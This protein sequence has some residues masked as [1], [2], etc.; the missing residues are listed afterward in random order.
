V[1]VCVCVCVCVRARACGTWFYILLLNRFSL[2]IRA[3]W[4]IAPYSLRVD[5]RFRSAYCL[6]Q[7][8]QSF[9]ALTMEAVRT[10]ET[11]VY[12]NEITRRYIADGSNL[13]TRRRNNLTS[14]IF[15]VRFVC[16]M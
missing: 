4:N 16:E 3:F 12:S 8:D 14:R 1:C 2:K 11:S 6:H 10:S 5:R 15:F 9:T 13:H 7:G